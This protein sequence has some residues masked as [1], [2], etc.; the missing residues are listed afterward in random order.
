MGSKASAMVTL[1]SYRDTKSMTRYYRLG[2]SIPSKPTAKPPSGWTTSEPTYTSGSTA[3]LYFC[4]LIEF[5]DGTYTYSAVNKSSSYQAA[6]EAYIAARN[7][8]V[9]SS[10]SNLI[11]NGLGTDKTNSNFNSWVFDGTTVC[12][13][14]P[15]FKYTG[16]GAPTL[17]LGSTNIPV[18]ISRA[19]EFS[20]NLKATGSEKLYLGWGEYDIDGNQITAEQSYS[21]S[22]TLTTLA[23]DLK[24]GDT[25]VYL[26]SA[27]AWHSSTAAHQLG[28]IF[29]NYKDSTNY[30]YPPGVYSRNVFL[31]LYTFDKVNKTANTITLKSAWNKGTFAAGT[32]VSQTNSAGWKYRN[33]ANTVVPATWTNTKFIING[34]QELYGYNASKFN[35]ATKYIRFIVLHNYG[36]S[37]TSATTHVNE[38]RLSDV[39][40]RLNTVTSVD[41]EY[42]LSS[43]STS[44]SG[45]SWSTTAPAWANGKYMW[46][47][48][49]KTN[50]AGVI[51]YSPS[52]NGVCIAG[53]KGAT[54]STGAAGKG[55]KSVS[56]QY[57]K[58]TSATSQTGG[59][60]VNSYPGWET[61]K[62]IW[63]RSIIA[64]TDNTSTTTAAVCVTGSPG[65]TGATGKG[66]KSTAITYQAGSSGTV[67]PTGTWG[68][69]PPATSASAPYLWTRTIITYTDN[70]TSTSYSVGSSPESIAIGGRNLLLNSKFNKD[71]DEWGT[72]NAIADYVVKKGRPCAHINHSSLQNTKTVS[73][74]ILGKIEPDTKYT[75]SG[76]VMTENLV[77]GSTNFT[78][79]FYCDGSYQNNGTATWYGYGSKNF[80]INAGKWTRLEW[81]FTTDSTK[82]A[83]ATSCNM[84]IHTR[85]CTGDIYFCDLKLEKG[86]RATDWAPA[87][88][89]MA[90]SEAL[91]STD[92]ALDDLSEKTGE[93]IEAVEMNISKLEGLISTLVIDSN[94][95]SLMKQTA[96]GWV[97]S[98]GET[99]GQL[100]AAIDE[101]EALENDLDAT[102]GDVQTLQ[103]VIQGLEA[104]TSYVRVTTDGNEP[105]IELGNESSF[106]V[107]ITN[108]A[109]KFM[110]GTTVPAYVSNQSLKIGKAVVEDELV[111]GG[112]A[113]AERSNGNMGLIW[114]GDDV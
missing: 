70:A 30:Q 92:Q 78:C 86:N 53:A 85:D 46:S 43:S 91:E 68:S 50:G 103:N 20:M 41:V 42:Y 40:D 64:Y 106:K 34:Y 52:Q 6:Q 66:V 3:S 44:L 48:T 45:G 28:L 99:L 49:V 60:W 7:A 58:S 83:A 10:T 59:S 19:Y 84:F 22:D 2:S 31:N 55:I 76:W 73:Q 95:G 14:Y 18:N 108:T 63:T 87:P 1:S 102:N 47:R 21:Y 17:F 37:S 97:F 57:Y 74:S 38:V 114:K 16:I 8:Q 35:Q 75:M 107:L 88:E 112:F 72:P 13:G 56:E 94:G 12:N 93:R 54:G 79:M 36:N 39:T 29:W 27:S 100:Q 24:N 105:C 82:L 25:T 110:D 33:Y 69:S 77:K 104:L 111:F 26:T 81:T 90:T 101:L 62:Y 4:D 80:P 51:T 109:I 65:A 23:K 71:A 89:D 98:M 113:F 11:I 32:K 5:S 9:T 61:G 67:V 15:S 96:D